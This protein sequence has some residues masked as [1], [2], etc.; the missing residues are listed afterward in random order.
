M[1]IIENKWFDIFMGFLGLTDFFLIT[2]NYDSK[3]GT[4]HV[5][6]HK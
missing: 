2:I 4:K 3:A 1:H 5:D 6:F